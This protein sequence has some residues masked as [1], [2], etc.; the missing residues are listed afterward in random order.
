MEIR[1]KELIEN[2]VEVDLPVEWNKRPT[3]QCTIRYNKETKK[4]VMSDIRT[5]EIHYSY[6][7]LSDLLRV[8]NKI[9]DYNDEAEEL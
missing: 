9:Y 2:G 1:S 8:T 6:S 4:F 3:R 5:K 7:K